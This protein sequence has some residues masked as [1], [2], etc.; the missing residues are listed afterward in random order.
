ML[1]ASFFNEMALFFVRLAPSMPEEA[2]WI[3]LLVLMI[4]TVTAGIDAVKAVVP[5]PLIFLGLFAVVLSQGLWASWD[6]AANHLR[7]AIIAGVLIWLIN[8]AWFLK[9]RTDALGMGDAKWTMLAVACFGAM[10]AL[11]AWGIGSVLATIFLGSFRLFKHRISRVY[12]S[13]FLLVG[14]G[15]ALYRVQL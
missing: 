5:D 12:F 1:D 8:Y 11:I 15:V 10:P 9:F 14:L 4:L 7:D 3:T 13:P 6:V 2:W